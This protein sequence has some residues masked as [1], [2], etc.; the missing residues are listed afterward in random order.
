MAEAARGKYSSFL[1]FLLA[2]G[3]NTGVTYAIYLLFLPALGYRLSYGI[4]YLTGIVISFFLNKNFVFREDRG[5]RSILLFP[6]VYVAQYCFNYA[7]IWVWVEALKLPTTLAPLVAVALAVPVTYL[8][9]HWVF[10]R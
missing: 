6:L 3:I 5:L 9:T 4:A 1:K 10:H 8:I 7:I 2:G